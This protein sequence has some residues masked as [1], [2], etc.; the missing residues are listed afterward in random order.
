MILSARYPAAVTHRVEVSG[1]DK[2]QT[3]FVEKSELVGDESAGKQIQLHAA[4]PDGAVIFLRLLPPVNIE[5]SDVVPYHTEFIR[6]TLEGRHQFRL[7]AVRP[8]S[9]SLTKGAALQERVDSPSLN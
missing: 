8:R 1:W 4:I 9:A 7:H 5:R 2:H 6:T 3:F